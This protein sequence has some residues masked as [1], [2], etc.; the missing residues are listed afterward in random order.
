MVNV[1]KHNI[2]IKLF[3]EKYIYEP[4]NYFIICFW[5]KLYWNAYEIFH[6]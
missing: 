1:Q 5:R 6:E 2:C 3:A 4:E